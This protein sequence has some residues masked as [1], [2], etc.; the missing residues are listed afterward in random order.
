MFKFYITFSMF[1]YK[2]QLFI[3]LHLTYIS[4]INE[5]YLSK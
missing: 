3:N 2:K 5:I 1:Y 4:N